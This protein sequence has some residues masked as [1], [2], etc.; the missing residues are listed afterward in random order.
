MPPQTATRLTLAAIMKKSAIITTLLI[1]SLHCS[2]AQ[3]RPV[4]DS[5]LSSIYDLN[6]SKD[7]AFSHPAKQIIAYG[8]KALPIL[9]AHFTDTTQT[10]IKSECQ[11]VY[12]TKGEVAIILA[13]RIELMRYA[14]LIGIQ[15][16]LMDF[17]KDNPNLI[18]YYLFAI[19]RDKLQAFQQRYTAWLNSKDR[20]KWTPYLN[21]K[22]KNRT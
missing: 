7:L 3:S 15:N 9:S 4:V 2:F 18:E 12:L 6:N 16:C 22:R 20:K 11:N 5:L 10:Q 21:N 1:F 17:C 13:D 8:E 14:T 19:R